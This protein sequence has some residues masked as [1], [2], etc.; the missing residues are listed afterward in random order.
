VDRG[1][2]GGGA[3]VTLLDKAYE[4]RFDPAERAA[5]MAI[6]AEITRYLQRFVRPDAPVLDIACDAGYFIEHVRASERWAT[7]LRD[8]GAHLSPGITFVCSDGLALREALPVGHFGTVFMSNYL[9]HLPSSD[10][11]IEQLRVAHDLLAPGGRV[12]V[13]QPNIRLTGPAYW[14]FIDHRVALTERSLVE[15]GDLAGLRTARLV[16]RFIPYTTKS[17]LPQ[18]A[19]LVR[20]Y[21]AFPPAWRILGQQTLYVAE[22][23][24]P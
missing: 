12:V 22:R 13:V 14:D 20:L 11:V 16:T 1:R 6:W 24:A 3:P 17:R 19:R 18:D 2:G 7:D 8:V 15:A 10:A 21:L 5:K 4:A 9:E 23:P